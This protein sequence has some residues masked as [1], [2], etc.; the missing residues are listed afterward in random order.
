MVSSD[1]LN[2]NEATRKSITRRLLFE[3]AHILDDCLSPGPGGGD[4]IRSEE[5]RKMWTDEMRRGGGVVVRWL[6]SRAV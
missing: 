4:T 1:L 3:R 6:R 2:L 5:R